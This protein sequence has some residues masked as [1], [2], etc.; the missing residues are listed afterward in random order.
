MKITNKIRRRYSNLSDKDITEVLEW[1]KQYDK[2]TIKEV[3]RKVVL[4]L[5]YTVLGCLVT[6]LAS[7]IVV[8]LLDFFIA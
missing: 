3:C 8:T 1:N 4:A 7:S 6:L 5:L 2:Q